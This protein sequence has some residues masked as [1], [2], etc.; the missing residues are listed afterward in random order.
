MVIPERR[1]D[2]QALENKIHAVGAVSHHSA[3]PA[4]HEI[5]LA[6]ALQRKNV[7]YAGR[8]WFYVMLLI[9]MIPEFLFKKL[10]L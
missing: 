3:L 7:I 2:L 4:A 1:S 5:L 6:N 9:R 10:K 8:V